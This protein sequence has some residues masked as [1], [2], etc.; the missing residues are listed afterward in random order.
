MQTK[1]T[2]STL[3]RGLEETQKIQRLLIDKQKTIRSTYDLWWREIS[4][5]TWNNA[6]TENAKCLIERRLMIYGAPGCDAYFCRTANRAIAENV[7][8]FSHT[9]Y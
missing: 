8:R 3:R 9:K 1:N 4:N 2:K 6:R 5:V 7:H